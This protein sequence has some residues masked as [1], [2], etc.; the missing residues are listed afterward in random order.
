VA[1]VRESG[2]DH[3]KHEGLRGSAAFQAN[4]DDRWDS[5]VVS[6]RTFSTRRGITLEF[7]G[8][9]TFDTP[10]P[11]WQGLRAGLSRADL[12]SFTDDGPVP[13]MSAG[14]EVDRG[15]RGT[16]AQLSEIGRGVPVG[17]VFEDLTEWHQFAL[18][19]FPSG[20]VELWMDGR[21][22]WSGAGAAPLPSAVRIVLCG[23]AT[24]APVL[25]DNVRVYEGLVFGRE[26]R[27][28]APKEDST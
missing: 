10:W 26:P 16:V 24:N 21:L 3:P 1:F 18:E 7:W 23:R 28:S 25:H 20:N 22:A 15:L 4:G 9:G 11:S 17:S 13:A 14:L 2:T 6:R 8:R 5:G 19:A 12:A 27:S